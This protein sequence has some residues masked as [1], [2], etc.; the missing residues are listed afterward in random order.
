MTKPCSITKREM[1]RQDRA[2]E[3]GRLRGVEQGAKAERERLI[4][5]TQ[6]RKERADALVKV[7]NSMSQAVSSMAAVL[8]NAHGVIL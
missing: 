8:D 3:L 1:K 4:Q 7:L 5:D 6:A 2:Y